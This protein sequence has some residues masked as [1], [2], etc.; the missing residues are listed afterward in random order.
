MK[1]TLTTF[2]FSEDSKDVPNPGGE[3]AS[4]HII[5][6]QN[7][8]RPPFVPCTYSFSVTLGL[9][10]LEDT[11][12]HKLEFNIVSPNGD[13][14]LTT[15]TI[16]LHGKQTTDQS[17]PKEAHG[18]TFNLDFRNVALREEGKYTGNTLVNG[19]NV[20][21]IPLWVYAGEN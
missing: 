10:G 18:L 13:V 1:P 19:V 14:V 21:T 4:L 3:G 17:L 2:V 6:P 12:D 5:N 20:G 16:N 9:I 7:V 15:G 8:F 11:G